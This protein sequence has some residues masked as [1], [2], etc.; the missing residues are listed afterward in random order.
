MNILKKINFGSIYH[1]I[2]S[3][4]MKNTW[5]IFSNNKYSQEDSMN[6]LKKIF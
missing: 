3:R 6:I 5:Y 2:I 4:L 1:K